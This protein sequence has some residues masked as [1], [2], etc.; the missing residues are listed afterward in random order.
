MRYAK[1][2]IIML[3]LVTLLTA[4]AT[5]QQSAVTPTEQAPQKETEEKAFKMGLLTPGSVNDEGWNQIAYDALLRVQDEL[6][7]E[8]GYVELE[9][10]LLF[11]VVAIALGQ[12]SLLL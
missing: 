12:S 2:I 11:E 6:G 7:S 4:C 9:Q 3:L 10:E 5:R 1:L 8:I